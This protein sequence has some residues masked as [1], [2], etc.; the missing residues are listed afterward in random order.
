MVTA[1]MYIKKI[2]NKKHVQY[3]IIHTPKKEKE[4][5]KNE[6]KANESEIVGIG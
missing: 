4:K 2:K 3:D 1:H 5:E 6:K